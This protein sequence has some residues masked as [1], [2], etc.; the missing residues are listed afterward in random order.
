M[1]V[2]KAS[3]KPSAPDIRAVEPPVNLVDGL[4]FTLYAFDKA[5]RI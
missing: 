4:P 3:Q 5:D 1:V 2:S